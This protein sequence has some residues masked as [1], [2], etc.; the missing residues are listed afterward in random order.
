[1][2]AQQ[3]AQ[4]RV[5]LNSFEFA[6]ACVGPRTES[7]RRPPLPSA[8]R[9]C[10][11]TAAPA[12]APGSCRWGM[13]RGWGAPAQVSRAGRQ[14]AAAAQQVLSGLLKPTLGCCSA[15]RSIA[16]THSC[17]SCSPCCPAPAAWRL[18]SPP[19]ARCACPSRARCHR[20]R[21]SAA[22]AAGPAG[23]SAALECCPHD[24]PYLLQTAGRPR[25]EGFDSAEGGGQHTQG[26]RHGAGGTGGGSPVAHVRR[27]PPRC[28]L[29][30]P[31]GAHL[32]LNSLIRRL[33]SAAAT[34]P[35]PGLWASSKT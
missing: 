11:R 1:M 5:M 32:K 10:C 29:P 12:A 26:W 7:C 17:I 34:M 8:R 35:A 28:R 6:P 14:G 18:T 20:Q 13:G 4:A 33:L 24:P 22:A 30:R 9:W 2:A 3:P 23:R 27:L 16:S 21:T 15:G 25:C 31:I 19:A